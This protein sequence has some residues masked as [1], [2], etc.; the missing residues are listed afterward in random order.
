MEERVDKSPDFE[1]LELT[2]KII[3]FAFTVHGQLG[4]GFLEK[5]YANALALEMCEAGHR[6]VQEAPIDV[7]YRGHVVGVYYA[8]LLVDDAVIC[9]IKAVQRLAPE[10][11]AQLLNYLKATSKAVGL[12]LNFGGSSVQVKRMAFGNTKDNLRNLRQSAANLPLPRRT[13]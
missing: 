10:H 7:S 1:F 13:K 11:E 12:L 8:D 2:R 3:G 6:V 9:E 4:N 5:V